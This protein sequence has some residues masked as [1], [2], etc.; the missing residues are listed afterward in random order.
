MQA[1]TGWVKISDTHLS[2][3]L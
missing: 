1:N 2:F 3:C